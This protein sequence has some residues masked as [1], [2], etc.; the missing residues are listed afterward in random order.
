MKPGAANNPENASWI[1]SIAN[2]T[3]P[4]DGEIASCRKTDAGQLEWPTDGDP[5]AGN[6]L[7][8]CEGDDISAFSPDWSAAGFEEPDGSLFDFEYGY[9]LS[10]PDPPYSILDYNL[11]GDFDFSTLSPG[12]YRVWG[13]SFLYVN[14][15][16]DFMS[17][18]DDPCIGDV[19]TIEDY[20]ACDYDCGVDV[21]TSNESTYSDEVLIE[22]IPAP[23][24]P[25]DPM[26]GS[27]CTAEA[28]DYDL[29]DLI[30][31][32]NNGTG[33]SV[34]FFDGNPEAG[35]VEIP[36]P[37][38][39]DLTGV[40]IWIEYGE[41]PCLISFDLAD[42]VITSG[43]TLDQI[44]PF[45]FCIPSG[46]SNISVDLTAYHD[47]LNSDPAL[48]FSWY[49]DAGLTQPIGNPST[50]SVGQGATT[51]YVQAENGGCESNVIPVILN[52]EN[53]PDINTG[54]SLE[55]CAPAPADF[56]L[57][58]AEADLNGTP[59][60]TFNWFE[61]ANG[62]GEIANPSDYS[63]GADD[64]YVSVTDPVS[65]CT[66]DTVSVELILNPEPDFNVIN[67]V[68]VCEGLEVDL[69]TLVDPTNPDLSYTFH[70]GFP[71]NSGN[72]IMGTTSFTSNTT[73]WV[74]GTDDNTGCTSVEEVSIDVIAIPVT[75]PISNSGP[76][77]EG[78]TI[79]LSYDF[80]IPIPGL[81]FSWTGPN[82]FSSSQE[83]PDIPNAP[84]AADGEYNLV[85]SL[86]GC[87]S[88]P[89]ETNVVVNPLPILDPETP[90]EICEGETLSL[91]V[92]GPPGTSYSWSGPNG[93]SSTDQNPEI[94]TSADPSDA[95]DYNVFGTRN[96]CIGPDTTVEVVIFES[97]D[98]EITI[99][100]EILCAG[101]SNG[102]ISV[103]INNGNAPF[104]YN[105]S[106]PQFDGLSS[107]T[108]LEAGSYS[109][110]VT[111]GNGCTSEDE[112][113]LTEPDPIILFCTEIDPESFPGAE[114]G[115]GGVQIS[116][117]TSP[118]DLTYD[119]NDGTN[120][121]I[122]DLGEGTTEIMGLPAGTYE[123]V[124]T[125]ANG[126]EV[127][128][129]FTIT[130]PGCEVEIEDI[131]VLVEI[132]CFGDSSA[133]LEAT[134]S[135]GSGTY[136]F[137]WTNSAG[138]EIGTSNPLENIPAGT[139][140]L[141]VADAFDLDCE[142]NAQIEVDEPEPLILNCE[143]LS[144]VSATGENDG[145][146]RITFNG[147]TPGYDIIIN[148]DL[149][150]NATSPLVIDTLSAGNYSM[151]L[152][153]FNGCAEECNLVLE[154]PDCD[155]EI[156]S[157]LI[158]DSLNCL[159][160]ST[161]I[162]TAEITG[163]P[164]GNY[165][166][167]WRR[168][169]STDTIGNTDTLANLFAGQYELIVR[170]ENCVAIDS[171]E[172]E[173]NENALEL[174]SCEV[175]QPVSA[176][177]NSDGRARI[178]W[179]GGNPEYIVN[180]SGG[181][182]TTFSLNGMSTTLENLPAGN[183]NVTLEDS[184]PCTQACSFSISD[185]PCD[186]DIQLD[187]AYFEGC[188][189]DSSL[190][191]ELLPT[192]LES[193][194]ILLWNTDTVL[195]TQR[196]NLAAGS[197]LIQYV[198]TVS[199]CRDSLVLN[200]P[201]P[202]GPS[203]NCFVIEQPS[204]AGA[205]DGRIGVAIDSVIKPYRATL[206]GPQG[207]QDSLNLSIDTV[208]WHE[209]GS[210]NY[211]I[212]ITDSLGCSA[213][214]MITLADGSCDLSIS[215]DTAFFDGCPDDSLLTIRTST[216]DSS[217]NTIF[218]W[219][220]DTLN[221]SRQ[222]NLAA[223]N[224]Q[225]IALDTLTQCRDTLEVNRPN[226]SML[227]F[228]CEV[229]SIPSGF[230]VGDGRAGLLID[231][232]SPPST[233][234]INGFNYFNQVNN[235]LGDSLIFS[236]LDSGTYIIT[237]ENGFGCIDSCTLMMPN[238]GCAIFSI[239]SI[240]P[241][242]ATCA[243]PQGGQIEVFVSGGSGDYT[244][245]WGIDSLRNQNPVL[246]AAPGNYSLTVRDTTLNCLALGTTF[247]QGA[248]DLQVS[249]SLPDTICAGETATVFIQEPDG[250][251]PYQLIVNGDTL[252]QFSGDT[253]LALSELA[254]T[255]EISDSGTCSYSQS[256]TI[257]EAPLA[258]RLIDRSLCPGDSLQLGDSTFTE[259][260]PI[261]MVRFPG[262][263]ANGCDSIVMVNLIFQPL[264]VDWSLLPPD[265]ESNLT[266]ALHI[267]NLDGS[268]PY[269]I[270]LNGTEIE[271]DS[272]P[273]DLEAEVGPNF[274]SIS[275]ITSCSSDTFEFTGEEVNPVEF[276]IEGPTSIVTGRHC[277]IKHHAVQCLDRSKLA[278]IRLSQLYGLSR[279]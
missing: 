37:S 24:D 191:I 165:N 221:I 44:G 107:L 269:R 250:L 183:Y 41:E 83:D 262:A 173:E 169:P 279:S 28:E 228:S 160:D 14:G 47:D 206:S 240:V 7:E 43:P 50:F 119:N 38:S 63:S 214:C 144:E 99:D 11:S 126:C 213:T 73:I 140:N 22:I 273:I 116:G 68:T 201:A 64:I 234:T 90:V 200:F 263:A 46:N 157:I 27:L 203:V 171:L 142:R 275:D 274:F 166:Y 120:G 40:D 225:I 8:L 249:L 155:L 110:T 102:A 246:N 12:T 122:L 114:D 106:D 9:V 192:S 33:L 101:G 255:L 84:P 127:T 210:G 145:S 204:Q 88:L 212:A 89:A 152:I 161:G 251:A 202:P 115:V 104:D 270:D 168:L 23:D 177:G 129:S 188:P 76:Y 205:E 49:E 4:Y 260:N 112:I 256:F 230:G 108:D 95:G 78:E 198:D 261:G 162:L 93:F 61:N 239:D 159:G 39:A 48:N 245:D 243:N 81:Q 227:N 229:F 259:T 124:V 113:E 132:Q 19:E 74:V 149:I 238:G 96:G 133:T 32:I 16:E 181:I 1:A 207:E 222:S 134:V 219:N 231:S 267:E 187:T 87:S 208:E 56:D 211:T 128:C 59:G 265:C 195:Q 139:Y 125:D 79:E 54:V 3:F 65:G 123:V 10:E 172:L 35:G 45:S 138:V 199:G 117:G 167:I 58:E 197:Y 141:T 179:V 241:Q 272:L 55:G 53:S 100:E 111:D 252:H 42:P 164:T 254:G 60:L 72:Q 248:T 98:I 75:P 21:S 217:N 2:G 71:P 62:S 147:G 194:T 257:V 247:V 94:T 220:Q 18:M 26:I 190:V 105:W 216:S 215:L 137:S 235:P 109:V 15:E 92:D 176:P 36:N 158:L 277:T 178:E 150:P 143:V 136:I 236:D 170:D 57:T 20:E 91:S 237:V 233:V 175:L 226:P 186:L 209:L 182:D 121:T 5:G 30:D 13:V 85:V 271:I 103:I 193:N 70:D 276:N 218:I 154:E 118:Y 52:V 77:C 146:I 69:D 174:L 148:G 163:G 17:F 34:T 31:I 224:Y 51:V 97:A 223:G 80:P 25:T 258:Q 180:I 278:A 264:T 189:S 6:V 130:D 67:D 185:I 29:T 242:A 131:S 135:N 156:A 253:T 151:E 196:S 266:T 232:L 268:P 244:Y 184:I 66:S 82:G 86:F 153:D